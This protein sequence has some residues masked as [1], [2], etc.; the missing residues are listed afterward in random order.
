M[1]TCFQ[2]LTPRCT[3]RNRLGI[4]IC[5]A[6][7]DSVDRPLYLVIQ[8]L[9][10]GFLIFLRT[11]SWLAD[12]RRHL[13]SVCMHFIKAF[14][15]CAVCP[16]KSRYMWPPGQVPQPPDSGA[17]LPRRTPEMEQS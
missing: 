6:R 14:L 11:C 16:N 1:N 8:A 4:S 5:G 9:A 13:Y 15:V 10:F 3:C 2:M 7:P 17:I 12:S